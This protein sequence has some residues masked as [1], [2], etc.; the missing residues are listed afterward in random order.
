MRGRVAAVLALATVGG[1]AIGGPLLGG[2]ADAF[3]ARAALA[4]GASL[5]I[6]GCLVVA[7]AIRAQRSS[8]A[9]SVSTAV[10]GSAALMPS[11]PRSSSRV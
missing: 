4:V 7:I 11:T 8:Q 3:G 2:M 5:V 9:W 6:G 10:F 1:S